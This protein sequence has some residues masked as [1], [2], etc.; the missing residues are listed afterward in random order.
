MQQAQAQSTSTPTPPSKAELLRELCNRSFHRFLRE[1]WSVI[2]HDPF[3][4]NW[5]IQYLCNE[6]QQAAERVANREPNPYDLI[7]NVPPGTSKTSVCS[8]FFPIWCWTKWPWMR[9]L[10]FSYTAPVSNKPAD[11]SMKVI[12][13]LSFQMVY[14]DIRLRKGKE[15]VT[16]YEISIFVKGYWHDTGGGRFSSSVGGTGTGFHG[17]F[18]IVDDPLN[19]EQSFSTVELNKTNRWVDQT[20]PTRKTNKKVSATIWVMQRLHQIDPSGHLLANKKLKV[21]HICLPA[22]ISDPDYAKLVSP[23]ELVDNYVDDLLDPVRLDRPTLLDLEERLGQ[24]GAAAQLGQNPTPPTGGMFKVDRFIILDQAPPDVSIK[25]MVRYWDKAG[26]DPTKEVNQG[27]AYTVGT[28][29]A[30]LANGKYVA[31]DVVRGRWSSEDREDM[32]RATAEA[33]GPEVK[34]FYEQEPG[35]GGKES[36]EA[37][38]RSLAG[39]SA[40]ADRPVKNKVARADTLAVQVNRYNVMLLR[41]EWNHEYIEEFRF[42]PNSRFKDQ[43]DSSSGAFTKLARQDEAWVMSRR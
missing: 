2:C 14:P 8:I 7:I 43:V 39:F 22:D 10:T 41:G 32:I 16:D 21:R 40:R 38:T 4:D 1:F 9:F 29:M 12:K 20:L 24:Y 5:H 34:V 23:P 33:D 19:P 28:K 18:L 31:M 30:V 13:S 36:A 17:D 15:G 35:S 6:L 3:Q 27:P 26:T 42:F 37:T 25:R 11:A